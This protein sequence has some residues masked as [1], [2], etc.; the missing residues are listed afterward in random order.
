MTTPDGVPWRTIQRLVLD[1]RPDRRALYARG[2]DVHSRTALRLTAGERSSLAT[3]F[4]AVPWA[5]WREHT[6]VR[7]LRLSATVDG[8]ALIEVRRTGPDGRVGTVATREATGDVTTEVDLPG[9]TAWVWIEV[10]AGTSGAVVRDLCWQTPEQSLPPARLTVAVTTFDRE[11]DC[12]RLLERLAA[13]PATMQCIESIVVA[14]QGTRRLDAADGFDRAADA[15]GDRLRV[16][17]QG[18][19]GG[20]GGFSRGMI[21]ALHGSSTHVLLLDDDVDLETESVLRLAA[22]AEHA[23]TPTIVGAQMLSLPQPS[24]LH[25]F[26]EY[27]DRRRMWWGPVDP[28]LSSLDVAESTPDRT[29]A[30]SRRIDVDFNGWWMCLIPVPLVRRTGASLPYFIKWDD[31]EYGLRASASG[32]PTVTLPGAALWHMPWTAKDDGL[33]WQAYFQ[34][35]NR[36]LTAL[37]HGGRGVLR[38]SFAQDANH[39]VCAQYGSAALRNLALRDVLS[40]PGHVESVLTQGPARPAAVLRRHGQVAVGDPPASA[41]A[42]PLPPAGAIAKMR[43]LAQVLGRQ[44]RGS[45]ADAVPVPMTREGGKWWSLGVVDAAVV[46]SATGAGAFVFRRSRG[47]AA[48]EL[49]DAILLRVRLWARW[50]TLARRYAEA[51]REAAS[52]SAW[53]ARFAASAPAESGD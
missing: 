10:V 52:P 3:F 37:L 39:V 5:Y 51:S 6:S 25:S 46:Q 24:I 22:F 1:D 16:V 35:R 14:D 19:L 44:L 42:A 33:D 18:N 2:G 9:D 15:L 41:G 27:V 49:S 31:A 21:E 23:R 53:E 11:G 32:V 29:P 40:G 4:G 12:V 13:D 38:A 43:R 36:V 30:M 45:R 26:G 28:A 20:S 7:R 17:R 8:E 47:T 50:R 48:R 34:L